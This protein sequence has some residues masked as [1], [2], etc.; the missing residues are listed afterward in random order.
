M[1]EAQLDDINIQYDIDFN[2]D[3]D[4]DA[5]SVASNES[6]S[7][8][9]QD[10]VDSDHEAAETMS[11]L[12]TAMDD[13]NGDDEDE[14]ELYDDGNKSNTESVI[15]QD[16]KPKDKSRISVFHEATASLRAKSWRDIHTRVRKVLDCMKDEGVNPQLFLDAFCWGTPECTR[17][18]TIKNARTS[19]MTS[20]ELPNI[21]RRWWKPPR[22][23]K[24]KK[25]RSRAA[26]NLM[27]KFALE[28]ISDI[29]DNEMN[30]LSPKLQ[31]GANSFVEKNLSSVKLQDIIDNMKDLAPTLWDVLYNAG[32]S[33]AQ[34]RRGTKKKPDKVSAEGI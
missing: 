2:F 12:H 24:S 34:E 10:G 4:D 21:I 29:R 20:K 14:W 25:S 19:F 31:V 22:S 8:E 1:L 15:A 28:C 26:R 30:A 33:K 5:V 32:H 23:R 13:G 17:D 6:I 3:S 27:E 7:I 18:P 16:G 9:V 11:D